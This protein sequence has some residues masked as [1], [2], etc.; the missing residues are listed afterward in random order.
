MIELSSYH[1]FIDANVAAI[2]EHINDEHQSDIQ[3]FAFYLLGLTKNQQQAL[4]GSQLIGIYKEGMLLDLTIDN[5]KSQRFLAFSQ[6]ITTLDDLNEAYV[7]LIQ[8]SQTMQGK[9]T[10]QV[11]EQ[12]FIVLDSYFITQN[13]LRLV[14]Q[15]PQNTPLIYAGYAYLFNI[16]KSL[17]DN[18]KSNYRYYTLRKAFIEREKT[19]AWIDIFIHDDNAGAN[20][21]KSLKKGEIITSKRE[22]PEKTEHL[23]QGQALLI[24]D[25]TSLPTVARLLEL[26][27]N[28]IAPIIILL[29]QNR[30]EQF[31]LQNIA[32]WH[33]SQSKSPK[34]IQLLVKN[35]TGNL[36][37]DRL[38][39]VAKNLKSQNI[40]ID[41]IWGG[42]EASL[43]KSLR[44]KLLSTL[45]LSRQDGVIK[46]Y[47][48]RN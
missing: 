3:E 16:G 10:I 22:F 5:Q 15:A 43:I 29:T 9:K 12:Q 30:S 7:A 19:I 18:E 32:N 13:M 28:P 17:E 36:L 44:N 2:I 21:A 8:Q 40:N 41:K 48:R 26:W 6:A 23:Q 14:L 24:A 20:W 31:Y 37:S 45:D 25:E 4:T 46:V 27:Q 1:R 38:L 33:V 34:M 11:I 39:E 35:Q 42:L 47:W